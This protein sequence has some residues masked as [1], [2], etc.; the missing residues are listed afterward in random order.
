MPS[1]HTLNVVHVV[2]ESCGTRVFL[3]SEELVNISCRV[4]ETWDLQSFSI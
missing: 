1:Y 3:F 2:V 4:L